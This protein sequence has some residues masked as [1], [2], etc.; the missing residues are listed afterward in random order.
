MLLVARM[1]LKLICLPWQKASI[2]SSSSGMFQSLR[3]SRLLT[4]PYTIVPRGELPFESKTVYAKV[5]HI[6]DS[7][8][9]DRNG[10]RRLDLHP[11]ACGDCCGRDLQRIRGR[12]PHGC[13]HYAGSERSARAFDLR[14]DIT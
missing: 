5:G 7:W 13:Q 12:I 6:Y 4:Y 3:A 14:V 10:L 11:N 9:V 8:R 1:R 2:M